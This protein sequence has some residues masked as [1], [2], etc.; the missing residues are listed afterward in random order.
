MDRDETALN[1]TLDAD[2]SDVTTRLVLSDLYEEAGRAEDAERE[3]WLAAVGKWPRPC[4]GGTYWNWYTDQYD[5]WRDSSEDDL[6][7]VLFGV[8][9]DIFARTGCSR[10]RREAEA[11]LFRV[12]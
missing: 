7:N 9:Y 3:R 11:D 4:A 10:T 8:R 2:P 5:S 6:H 1:A 12:R